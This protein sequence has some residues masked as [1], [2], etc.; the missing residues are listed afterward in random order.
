MLASHQLRLRLA[1]TCLRCGPTLPKL[2]TPHRLELLQCGIRL[3]RTLT[4]TW[5]GWESGSRLG[6]RL[7]TMCGSL[8]PASRLANGRRT[9]TEILPQYS[10]QTSIHFFSKKK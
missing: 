8:P 1:A 4:I 3:L 5:P 9:E 10:F 6:S 2:D 7:R